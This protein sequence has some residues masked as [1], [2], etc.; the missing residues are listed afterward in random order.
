MVSLCV[1]DV[2]QLSICGTI[3]VIVLGEMIKLSE[4]HY[5]NQRS[6]ENLEE[7]LFSPSLSNT[8]ASDLYSEFFKGKLT[9]LRGQIEEIDDELETRKVIHKE[10]VTEIDHQILSASLFLDKLKH[11]AIGYR[12]GVDMERNLWERQVADLTKQKRMEMVRLWK[13][14]S[15]L[16]EDRRELLHEYKEVYKRQHLLR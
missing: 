16:K 12:V 9:S 5:Y 11:W 7:E 8:N 14:S 4:N 2:V 10:L 6:E 1:K 15:G 13:D 3:M